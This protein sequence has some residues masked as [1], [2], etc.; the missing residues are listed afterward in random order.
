MRRSRALQDFYIN[1][2]DFSYFFVIV[3]HFFAWNSPASGAPQVYGEKAG[4]VGASLHSLGMSP[5]RGMEAMS[6]V[7][8]HDVVAFQVVLR[9]AQGILR[10]E[11]FKGKSLCLP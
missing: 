9:V 3:L 10:I 4:P 5:R 2:R 7:T 8:A 6:E 11:Y 1:I